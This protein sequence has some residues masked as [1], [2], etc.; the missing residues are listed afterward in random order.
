[1][2]P[3]LPPR[4]SFALLLRPL[5]SPVPL[6]LASVS[7]PQ[8]LQAL[9]PT[10]HEN[11][12]RMEKRSIR[13]FV[14]KLDPLVLA[15][16]QVLVGRVPSLRHGVGR[17]LD[18]IG[19][20]FVQVTPIDQDSAISAQRLHPRLTQLHV[21]QKFLGIRNGEVIRCWSMT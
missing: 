18:P 21:I 3:L 10:W 19:V 1:M 2:P 8:A 11:R 15:F 9:L 5:F 13:N 12:P 20:R 16:V 17:F 7:L 6:L 14:R 4:A